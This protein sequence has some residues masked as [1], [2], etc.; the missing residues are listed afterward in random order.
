MNGNNKKLTLIVR[1]LK[2][3]SPIIISCDIKPVEIYD[4]K[5]C[6]TAQYVFRRCY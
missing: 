4:Y 3:N 1:R 2:T 6:L 5:N